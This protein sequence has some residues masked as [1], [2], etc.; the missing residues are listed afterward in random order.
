MTFGADLFFE[1]FFHTLHALFVLDLC[2]SI[3]YSI[4][5]IVIGKI[6]LSRL[7]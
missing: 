1:K 6:Q 7:I 4:N 3:F 5:C 2:K